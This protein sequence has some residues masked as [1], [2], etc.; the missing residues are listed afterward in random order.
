[1]GGMPDWAGQPEVVEGLLGMTDDEI[2][3]ARLAGQSLVQIAADKGVTEEALVTAILNAKK[4]DLD[5][6]VAEGKLTQ[7]QAD[8]MYQRM[9]TQVPV[10]VN[11]TA[12]GPMGR[13]GM[14]QGFGAGQGQPPAGM[15][16]GGMM[17]PRWGR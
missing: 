10:M 8:L 1:M 15:P 4:A 2:H 6:A 13:G 7:A 16:R 3:A 11:Q 14:M 17:G 12:V 5:Q 9:Q